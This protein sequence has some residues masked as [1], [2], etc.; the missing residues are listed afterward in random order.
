MPAET[1]SK[2]TLPDGYIADLK[3]DCRIDFIDTSDEAR[4]LPY[5]LRNII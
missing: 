4:S 1:A 3:P 2:A 5:K